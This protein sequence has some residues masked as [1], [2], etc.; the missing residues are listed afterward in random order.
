MRLVLKKQKKFFGKATE[1]L[2]VQSLNVERAATRMKEYGVVEELEE[3][4][5]EEEDQEGE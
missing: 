5:E 3:E 1:I 2:E 4:D